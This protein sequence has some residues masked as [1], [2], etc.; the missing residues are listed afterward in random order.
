MQWL[1]ISKVSIC[2]ILVLFKSLNVHATAELPMV[3][4][5]SF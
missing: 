2:W 1:Y 4:G 3:D 5:S